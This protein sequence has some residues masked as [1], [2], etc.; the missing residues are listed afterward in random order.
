[1]DVGT[2]QAFEFSV[3]YE[4]TRIEEG[5]SWP[6][7]WV[8]MLKAAEADGNALPACVSRERLDYLA[9]C[10]KVN[11]S[12]QIMWRQKLS[13]GSTPQ[14]PQDHGLPVHSI[15]GV[16]A[17]LKMRDID[18]LGCGVIGIVHAL[19]GEDT[20]V[21]PIRSQ[22][23]SF[24]AVMGKPGENVDGPDDAM[25]QSQIDPAEIQGFNEESETVQR[26]WPTWIKVSC[27]ILSD[28][29]MISRLQQQSGWK[30][31][32]MGNTV[33]KFTLNR[34]DTGAS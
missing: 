19:Y 10:E 21:I 34:V 32:I 12:V 31:D 11:Q 27:T 16:R 4:L 1:M 20:V 22:K 33:G 26:L 25:S 23:W 30:K 17:E 9:S 6:G 8:M 15:Y 28:S 13:D 3:T 7:L 14:I 24:N 5:P 2:D 29:G 18:R